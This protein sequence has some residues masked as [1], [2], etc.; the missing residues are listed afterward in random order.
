M[1]NLYSRRFGL[2]EL[3]KSSELEDDDTEDDAKAEGEDSPGSSDSE[4]DD[5][6]SKVDIEEENRTSE[7]VTEGEVSVIVFDTADEEDGETQSESGDEEDVDTP[8]FNDEAFEGALS[9][10]LA[11]LGAEYVIH[12]MVIGLLLTIHRAD[13]I[14]LQVRTTPSTT[15]SST[16]GP[17][18]ESTP[19][20]YTPSPLA[21]IAPS[22]PKNIN[23]NIAAGLEPAPSSYMESDAVLA[24]MFSQV[25]VR[26][27]AKTRGTLGT[28]RANENIS[29]V[30]DD[31]FARPAKRMATRPVRAAARRRST[32]PSPKEAEIA[33]PQAGPSRA[34]EP[35][36]EASI[37]DGYPVNADGA[38]ECLH[39]IE[40][41]PLGGTCLHE[42]AQEDGTVVVCNKT[43][44]GRFNQKKNI[45]NHIE[46]HVADLA[47]RLGVATY[48]T[49]QVKADCFH[50]GCGEKQEFRTMVRHIE[51]K[52][53]GV[54]RWNCKHCDEAQTPKT[55]MDRTTVKRHI[56]TCT[57]WRKVAGA[58]GQRKKGKK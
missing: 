47:K 1:C 32:E 35:G 22:P 8:Q 5:D 48:G 3:D 50:S 36:R 56:N 44:A 45:H 40:L 6:A 37:R 2:L 41:P 25:G 26:T 21:V 15:P 27:R 46:G 10:N 23:L 13:H 14:N 7:I 20:L 39:A 53:Y 4:D 49:S 54:Q 18:M 17:S 28:K 16:R 30:D 52:H 11:E 34:C 42:S 58:N 55:T 29:E 12:K 51:T 43:F 9:P 57:N 19:P 31:V 33:P 38:M 24:A